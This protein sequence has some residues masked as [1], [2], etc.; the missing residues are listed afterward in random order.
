MPKCEYMYTYIYM[1]KNVY[2]ITKRIHNPKKKTYT[3][4][5]Q[6]TV[7]QNIKL[8]KWNKN[9]IQNNCCALA[10]CAEIIVH[11]INLILN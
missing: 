2:I 10:K 3:V 6:C 5:F 4:L 11:Q 7:H 1:C 9:Q 8:Q